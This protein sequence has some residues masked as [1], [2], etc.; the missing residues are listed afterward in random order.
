MAIGKS[1]SMYPKIKSSAVSGVVYS[2]CKRALS[3][4]LATNVAENNV[5]EFTPV[6]NADHRFQSPEK[7]DFVIA[8][9]FAFF[10]LK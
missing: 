7:M 4:S 6:E 3:R 2:L 5:I 8:E 10:G 9:L 1:G